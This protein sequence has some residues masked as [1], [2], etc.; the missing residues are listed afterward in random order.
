M[1]RWLLGW[2]KN[3]NC[4]YYDEKNHKIDSKF[5]IFSP[6]P[7]LNDFIRS[8]NCSVGF[9][10]A[11]KSCQG[12]HEIKFGNYG[13]FVCMNLT[14]SLPYQ[15]IFLSSFELWRKLPRF[16][17]KLNHAT[18]ANIDAIEKS[19]REALEGKTKVV[20]SMLWEKRLKWVMQG[21]ERSNFFLPC[22]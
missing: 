4:D 18:K 17:F 7:S 22:H 14:F 3:H 6:K 11:N 21:T 8:I 10:F 5:D 12:S 20:Q 2:L 9:F 13:I 15:T 16:Q 1:K 19:S